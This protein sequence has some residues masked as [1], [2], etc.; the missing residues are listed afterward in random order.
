ML[1]LSAHELYGRWGTWFMSVSIEPES[2]PAT[3]DIDVH[4]RMGEANCPGAPM[5]SGR[6]LCVD[7]AYGSRLCKCEPGW[8][9]HLCEVRSPSS[10]SHAAC[11]IEHGWSHLCTGY[12]HLHLQSA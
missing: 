12:S 8:Y 10:N 11:A 7:D 4:L 3:G 2:L 1:D 9:G 6:G 5:C